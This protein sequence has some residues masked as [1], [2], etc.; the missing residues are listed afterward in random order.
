MALPLAALAALA[1]FAPVLMKYMGIGQDSMPAKVAETAAKVATAVTG[2]A[3][4]D[5]AITVL[6][7]DPNKAFEFR[8]QMNA[9]EKEMDK[10]YLDDVANARQRDAEFVKAGIVNHRANIMF[11][12]AWVV[13]LIAFYAVWKSQG[14]DDFVKATIT[15]IL[16]RF[17]GYLD[18]IYQ[19]EFGST[20][21]N[22]DKDQAIANLTY[23]KD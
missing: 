4:V 1:Q 14:L 20:R 8:I 11:I 9:H 17:L 13:V 21:S 16:G 7:S 22:K 2:A 6:A 12:M 18:Q 3:S 10:M 15:L 5:D 23:R 19:F